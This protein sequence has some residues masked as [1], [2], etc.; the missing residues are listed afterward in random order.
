MKLSE[1]F[2]PGMKLRVF[3]ELMWVSA[4]EDAGGWR[5]EDKMQL[6]YWAGSELKTIS[7]QGAEIEGIRAQVRDRSGNTEQVK[8]AAREFMEAGRPPYGSKVKPISK[9]V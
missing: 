3:G 1:E 8:Q 5:R 4:V 2:K 7:V 9:R 6:A